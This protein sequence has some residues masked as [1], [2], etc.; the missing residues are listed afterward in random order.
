MNPPMD[1]REARVELAAA[2][3]LAVMFDFHEGISNHFSM[4]IPGRDDRFLINPLG[5]HF[6]EVTASSLAVV[7]IDGEQ[8]SGIAPPTGVG[9]HSPIHRLCSQARVVLHT[10]Q[11]W[12]TALA[13]KNELEIVP[14]S[15]TSLQFVGRT[16]YDEEYHGLADLNE[17]ERLAKVL[18]N[19]EIMLMRHHG[20][21]V[22]GAELGSAF[23]DLFMLEKAAQLQVLASGLGPLTPI[24]P[25]IIEDTREDM[26][27]GMT[28]WGRMHWAALLRMVEKTQP[29]FRD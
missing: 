15:Q 21:L 29:D 27:S 19:D 4:L 26:M 13:M 25:T 14:I 9:I 5:L 3:R 20:V 17:G 16:A 10:H 11:P 23:D 1:E 18:G 12:S 24:D 7:D 6:S 28:E 22:A 2:F 8:I